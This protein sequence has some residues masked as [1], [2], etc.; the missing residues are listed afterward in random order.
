VIEPTIDRQKSRRLIDKRADGR[1]QQEPTVDPNIRV[2]LSESAAVSRSLKNVKGYF[3]S[4]L[5]WRGVIPL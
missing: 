3:G 5:E 2:R 1:S 4:H